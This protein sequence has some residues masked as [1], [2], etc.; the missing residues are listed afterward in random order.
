[1]CDH[2]FRIRFLKQTNLTQFT[3]CLRAILALER[4]AGGNAAWCYVR[5][6]FGKS[7]ARSRRCFAS[8]GPLIV[9]FRPLR[10]RSVMGV[11]AGISARIR[12]AVSFLRY[13]TIRWPRSVLLRRVSRCWQPGCVDAMMMR[14]LALSRCTT[15]DSCRP[16]ARF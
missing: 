1:M 5:V 14:S 4:P 11:P 16:G 2:Y 6:T 13:P 8:V 9:T 15:R 3:E 12:S 10:R 7:M